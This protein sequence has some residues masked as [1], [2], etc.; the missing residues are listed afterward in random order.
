MK[1]KETWQQSHRWI[2]FKMIAVRNN[3]STHRSTYSENQGKHQQE[4]GGNNV[5][6]LNKN[7]HGN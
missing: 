1:D 7:A 3:R 2:A 4:E 6:I 5:G